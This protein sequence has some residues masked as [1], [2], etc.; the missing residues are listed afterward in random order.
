MA[1][2]SRTRKSTAERWALPAQQER[3]RE[4]RAR[5]FEAA[6]EV[7][8]EK[9]Y[10][11]ARLSDIAEAAGCSVGAVYF[12]FKD[13]DALFSAIAESFAE[14]ARAGLAAFLAGTKHADPHAAIRSFVAACAANLKRHKGLLRAIVERGLD[15]PSAMKTIFSFRDELAVALETALGAGGFK[16]RVM[17]QMIYGFLITGVLNSRAPTRIE[18]QAAIEE[19][20]NACVAY[21]ASRP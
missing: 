20:G 12:R 18:D 15:H 21:F 11:G 10:E 4:T 3:S 16:I 6:E 17:T 14:D 1:T 2:A 7:F 8:A 5:I 19:L 9:G 13:K